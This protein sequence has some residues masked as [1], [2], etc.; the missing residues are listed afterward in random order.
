MHSGAS[1]GANAGIFLVQTLFGLYIMAVMLRLLFGVARVDFYNPISQM[2][3][4]ITNPPLLP[5]RRVVPSVGMID[6]SII[7]LLLLLQAAEIGLTTLLS[8]GIM[9][10]PAIAVLSAAKLIKL[11]T[12]VLFFTII[13]EVIVSW[14]PNMHHHPIVAIIY[15][16]NQPFI[17]PARR[18]MPDLSGIDLSPIL[19]IIVLE[20]INLLVVAPLQDIAMGLGI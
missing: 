15:G 1:Y 14:F 2:L 17:T 10:L 11:F 4:K 19:V 3:V 13:I 9:P 18:V 16:V 5:L 8:G 6:S 12:S 7:L 20:L